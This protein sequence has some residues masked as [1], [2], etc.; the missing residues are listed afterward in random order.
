MTPAE[1]RALQDARGYAMAGRVVYGPHAKERMLERKVKSEDVIAALTTAN[2]CEGALKGRWKM[3]GTDRS[4]DSLTL[5]VKVV[6]GVL[7]LT[8]Y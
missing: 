5:I 3:T 4:G 8:V 6:G 1:A 7:V 2:V